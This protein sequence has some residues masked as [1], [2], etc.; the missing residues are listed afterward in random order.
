MINA[1][2]LPSFYIIFNEI[3]YVLIFDIIIVIEYDKNFAFTLE[4][5]FFIYKD[6]FKD[7]F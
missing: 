5:N 6:I 7:I 2:S 3:N 4:C 1:K